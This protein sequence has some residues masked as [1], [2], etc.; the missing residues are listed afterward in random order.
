MRR[1]TEARQLALYAV[2]LIA[3]ETAI[4]D[5]MVELLVETVHKIGTRSKRKVVGDIAKD[6]ERVYGKERVLVD[7]ATASID[8]PDGRICDVIFPI[9]GSA[10]ASRLNPRTV[11]ISDDGP[12]SGTD[13]PK[14]KKEYT[15]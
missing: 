12:P 2:Y 14:C 13:C 4:T 6:V 15:G 11:C 1:H 10:P 8:D 5:A 3:R 7:I 9:V